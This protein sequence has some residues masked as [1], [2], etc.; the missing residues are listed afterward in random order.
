VLAD[1]MTRQLKAGLS[2]EVGIYPNFDPER[3][4][5]PATLELAQV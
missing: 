3:S 1:D 5:A 2:N 4:V